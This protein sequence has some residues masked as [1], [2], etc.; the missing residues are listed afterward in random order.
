MEIQNPPKL[1]GPFM[2]QRNNLNQHTRSISE[3]LKQRKCEMDIKTESKE[4]SEFKIKPEFTIEAQ[5]IETASETAED[6]EKKTQ[7]LIE[8][9][10][11]EY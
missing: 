7:D 3:Q 4:E 9:R 5:G 8:V 11:L 2:N 1:N 10:Y 6:E